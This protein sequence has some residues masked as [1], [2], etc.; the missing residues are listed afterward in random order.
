MTKRIDT[1][2]VTDTSAAFSPAGDFSVGVEFET[3][4]S[5]YVDIEVQVD[6][7]ATP[8]SPWVP[9]G[10]ISALDNPPI[11]RFAKQP[12]VRLRLYNNAA[13]KVARAW[14]GE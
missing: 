3:G 4:S 2:A 14:S 13:G 9:I 8:P 12:S 6:G 7:G 5:A 11:K 10:T 1:T